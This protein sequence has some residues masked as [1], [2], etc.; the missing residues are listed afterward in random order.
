MVDKAINGYQ[1]NGTAI[2]VGTTFT[3]EIGGDGMECI[4]DPTDDT[5]MYGALYYGDI[6]RSTN[7]GTTFSG[8]AGSITETGG[9][10]TPY[11]LDPNNPNRMFAGFDN[12]WRNDAVRTGTSWTRIS[13]F[14]GTQNIRDLAVAPSNSDVLYC[15][16]YDNSFRRSDNA[17]AASPTWTDLTANLPVGNEPEDIEIDPTDPTHVFIALNN[18]IYESTNSGVTWTDISGTLPNISLNTIVIDKDSPLQAMYVGMDVGVYYK[19]NTMADWALYATGLPNTEVTELEIHYNA[20]TCNS[21]LYAA[22]YGQGLWKSDLKDPGNVA[23]TACFS[24]SETAVCLGEPVIFT[25]N[26]SYTPTSWT[27]TVTPATYTFEGGTNANS[28]NP[29]I[30]FT[31]AG[32]YTIEL[33]ASNATGPDTETKAAYI[34]VSNA[35]LGGTVVDDFEAEPLCATTTDCAATV[36]SLSGFWTNLSNGTDDNIDWRTDEGGTPSSNTG[37]SVDYNPGTAAGNYLYLEAS[38]GCTNQTAILESGCVNLDQDYIFELAYHMNGGAMGSLHL[39]IFTG[40]VWVND[41]VPSISGNQGTSWNVL[42]AD[43]TPYT[44][45]TI[46]LRVRGVTGTG[47]ESDMAIDD[48]KFTVNLLD[49]EEPTVLDG[50]MIYPNPVSNLLT[51]ANPKQLVLKNVTLYDITGRL[52]NTVTI[53]STTEEKTIDVSHLSNGIY[54]ITISGEQGTLTKKLVKK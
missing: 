35:V 5:Y 8:I 20:A 18:N 39:D 23:V 42:N 14:G 6:R 31:A 30:S 32:N 37:P 1:D 3:T 26:S 51:I 50:L 29:Q 17:T 7:G 44:G 33:T 22:T 24:A 45:Q 16:R 36:C 53:D 9:W 2:N 27:W 46:K 11:K 4:I 54:M 41:F 49:V 40:G 12:I 19:D 10:V 38:G 28:Q 47:F 34:T 48:L 25:D 43:L 21:T 15:S 52:I 13:N